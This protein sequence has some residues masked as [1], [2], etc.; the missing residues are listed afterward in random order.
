MI[1]RVIARLQSLFGKKTYNY[2]VR[3]ASLSFDEAYARLATRIGSRLKRG[4]PSSLM[5]PAA[6][7]EVEGELRALGLVVQRP[8]LQVDAWRAYC[9][10]A[11]YRSR[12][13]GYYAANLPEKSLEH[14]LGLSFLN[15][16]PGDAFVDVAAEDSPVAEIFGRL[17]GCTAYAQDIMYPPGLHGHRLGC[18]AS[19]FPLPNGFFTKSLASC[20]IEHFEQD[21][22]TRFFL[23]MERL[24]RPGGR[25]VVA[26][27]Y[28]HTQPFCQTDPINAVS[29]KL[30]FEEFERVCAVE[31]W[32]NRHGRFY[33]PQTLMSRIVSR[34]PSLRY[35]VLRLIDAQSIDESIYARFAL[36]AEKVG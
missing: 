8:E 26:P 14:F 28:I 16:Q 32:G 17:T 13:P 29:A 23:E 1:D 30:A 10:R 20:S 25:I 21:A 5:T 15:L 36:V 11:E 9:D 27:L 18:D 22:D 31:G 12:Y 7:D 6:C 24:L 2:G 34:T 3:D 33:S 19:A 35:T 4:A